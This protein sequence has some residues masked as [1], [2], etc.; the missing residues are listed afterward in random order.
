MGAG[1]EKEK[2]LIISVFQRLA[3][4]LRSIARPQRSLLIAID[5]PPPW[6]KM[7]KQRLRRAVVDEKRT[8]TIQSSRFNQL[9]FTPGSLFM[10]RLDGY[11]NYFAA[12]LLAKM[13]YLEE[14]IVSGSRV[15]GEGEMKIA[16]YTNKKI[17]TAPPHRKTTCAIVTGDA[18]ALIYALLQDVPAPVP[19]GHNHPIPPT[20]PRPAI[21]TPD[22]QLRFTTTGLDTQL[23]TLFPST[24]PSELRRDLSILVLLSSG[25]DYVP[26]MLY[27]PFET[28]WESYCEVRRSMASNILLA[29]LHGSS[30]NTSTKETFLVSA[31]PGRDHILGNTTIY[32]IN[33]ILLREVLIKAS[34]MSE[35]DPSF[36][37]LLDDEPDVDVVMTDS[38]GSRSKS[39]QQQHIQVPDAIQQATDY[40]TTLIWVLSM[41][42]DG[43]CRD[44][45]HVYTYSKGPN[46]LQTVKWIDWMINNGK[47]GQNGVWE[48]PLKFRVP[49]MPGLCALAVL[50]STS[51]QL[52]DTSLHS[53]LSDFDGEFKR[54]CDGMEMIQ[55]TRRKQF[56]QRALL[57]TIS[58]FDKTFPRD[59][60]P[61]L[62]S[63]SASTITTTRTSN[64]FA[65]PL[66]I[67][68]IRHNKFNNKQRPPNQIQQQNHE[69]LIIPPHKFTAESNS[70]HGDNTFSI[71]QMQRNVV[72]SAGMLNTQFSYEMEVAPSAPGMRSTDLWSQWDPL[73]FDQGVQNQV[74]RIVGGGG[75]VGDGDGD[76]SMDEGSDGSEQASVA[77]RLGIAL[78]SR[79]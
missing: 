63:A 26:A 21:L 1:N 13:P 62:A 14:V 25:D 24:N 54:R 72:T 17:A 59:Y 46:V 77:G 61:T 55:A 23:A 31:R 27:A 28:V 50:P 65:T 18:D 7:L 16:Q 79:S 33:L 4:I 56:S 69:G 12:E 10:S 39:H 37:A 51:P 75:T 9:H 43:L 49:S 58:H 8:R 74:V 73:V 2:R 78:P 32:G 15:P 76:M 67:R 3:H 68:R 38:K 30:S 52:I 57:Q 48:A 29:S 64:T 53:Q 47:V 42:A 6:S 20:P 45:Q 71:T 40:F 66:R 70:T 41:T 11:M 22:L 5:G 19:H 35:T 60:R 36:N 44:Y 34:G